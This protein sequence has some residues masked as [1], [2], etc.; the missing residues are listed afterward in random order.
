MKDQLVLLSEEYDESYI[1]T[2]LEVIEGK[3][4]PIEAFWTSTAIPY[5]DWIHGKKK[6]Y[7]NRITSAWKD[8]TVSEDFPSGQ[9]GYLI[10]IRKDV[11]IYLIDSQE[12]LNEIPRLPS[13]FADHMKVITHEDWY[14]IDFQKL[15][16]MGYDGVR[17]TKRASYELHNGIM[18]TWDV[19]ST[20][21]LT[22]SK[23]FESVIP[24]Y[25]SE[26]DQYFTRAK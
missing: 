15:K 14:P 1:R 3:N 18:N 4:K 25:S 21:W 10:K 5:T 26:D 8:W 13:K 12:D 23:C 22:G 11:N 7:K 9:F 17:L 24:L 20:C 2:N 16:N 19:E 6:T